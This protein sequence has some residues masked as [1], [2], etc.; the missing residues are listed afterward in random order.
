MTP[1][2]TSTGAPLMPDPPI[3]IPNTSIKL[4]YY[5][6]KKDIFVWNLPNGWII[7]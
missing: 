3:S 4:L 2:L 1:F 7:Q 5:Q 6:S